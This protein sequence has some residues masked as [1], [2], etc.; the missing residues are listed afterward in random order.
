[1]ADIRM[2]QHAS[3]YVEYTVSDATRKVEGLP[4]YVEYAVSQIARS[5]DHISAYIEYSARAM[6]TKTVP[7]GA[8]GTYSAGAAA[9]AMAIADIAEHNQFAVGGNDLIIVHNTDV[10]D[11]TIT[12][13]S[14]PDAF[15]RPENITAYNIPAGEY[16]IFGPFK[17]DGWMQLDRSIYID[18]SSIL[19]KIGVVEL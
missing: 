10:S 18:A 3:V 5:V 8:Y 11:H 2:L 17:P 16:H 14:V 1:M 19:L 13:Y 7:L 4:A 15:G 12:I 6:I 9:L